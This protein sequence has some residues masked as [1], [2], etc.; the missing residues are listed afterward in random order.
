MDVLD[1]LIE[2]SVVETK[3]MQFEIDEMVEVYKNKIKDLDV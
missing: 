1:E 3:L 2:L